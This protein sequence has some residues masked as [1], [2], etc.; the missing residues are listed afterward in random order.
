M[1]FYK[2]V[3]QVGDRILVRGCDGYKEIR[4]RD[5][6]RPTLYVKSKKESKFTTLYG[7]HVRPIQPGGIRDCK[8]FCQQYEDVDGFEISGNQAYLYQW[9]SDN[10]PGEV[11]YDPSKI[12]VFTIDIETAAENGF[13][14][15]E[16]AD[17]EILLISVLS[18]IHI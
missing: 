6:F 8:Q 7:E 2:N 18:L 13:P 9:I 17:Q 1:K 10:F 5:E 15:I 12:R 3:D 16:S 11:D 14:D 4:F